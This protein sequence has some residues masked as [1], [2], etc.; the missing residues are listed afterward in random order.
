[1]ISQLFYFDICSRYAPLRPPQL[2]DYKRPFFGGRTLSTITVRNADD[3]EVVISEREELANILLKITNFKGNKAFL[4]GIALQMFGATAE[5]WEDVQGSLRLLLFNA[6]HKTMPQVLGPGERLFDVG[7]RK[8]HA[9][10]AIKGAIIP[11]LKKQYPFLNPAGSET[12]IVFNRWC[13]RLWE[14][15]SASE[16]KTIS[17]RFPDIERG[18]FARVDQISKID[19]AHSELGSVCFLDSTKSSLLTTA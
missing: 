8:P 15:L 10:S 3:E 19:W 7:P 12:D 5:Q 1:M 17:D 16:S 9:R 4:H 13:D 14:V 18:T 2:L 11:S 6:S